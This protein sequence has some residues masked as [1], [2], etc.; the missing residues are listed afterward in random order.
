MSVAH[1]LDANVRP[2]RR[3]E[4][5]KLVDDGC[6]EDEPVEL[7]WGN[8]VRM[9]PQRS[10][11]AAAVQYLTELFVLAVAPKKRATVRIQSPFAATDDSEPEPDVAI[12]PLGAYRDAHPTEALLIVEV[13]ETSLKADRA[14]A[15][16]Y[17]AAGV[18]EYWI[19]N[20]TNDTVEV[21]RQ[22]VIEEA[23]YASVIT[24]GSDAELP[25]AAV[26]DCTLRLLELFGTSS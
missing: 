25:V 7:L 11:H 12:V 14:K 24:H 15:A 19:V 2:L 18:P 1:G 10:A 3:S 21:H 9:N 17:A 4:Y 20:L 16:I 26:P 8:L 6:F 13:A 22:P 5:D 23:R